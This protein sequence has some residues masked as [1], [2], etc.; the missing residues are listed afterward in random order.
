MNS[1]KDD[2]LHI[3]VILNGN[4]QMQPILTPAKLVTLNVATLCYLCGKGFTPQDSKVCVHY[5]AGLI[6][7]RGAAHRSCSLKYREQNT[8]NCYFHNLSNYDAHFT[9]CLAQNHI[10]VVATVVRSTQVS[11]TTFH[12]IYIYLAYL[13]VI[14]LI[15][16]LI[17]MNN[18]FNLI[19]NLVP[20]QTL[21]CLY[22]FN[23]LQY[24]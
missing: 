17:L 18:Y 23:Q 19:F 2:V 20:K 5:H 3:G 6:S 12:I 9:G 22:Q 1:I 11:P 21:P 10:R 16:N 14:L 24:C 13:V 8:I 7:Q 15:F 4:R